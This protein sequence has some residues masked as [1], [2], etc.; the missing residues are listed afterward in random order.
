MYMYMLELNTICFGLYSV[1]YMNQY[2][3]GVAF[4]VTSSLD[5]VEPVC[6]R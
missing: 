3:P 2:K 1:L 4:M 5:T 6:G